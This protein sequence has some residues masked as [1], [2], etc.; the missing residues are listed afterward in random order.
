MKG[1]ERVGE[2][3][4]GFPGGPEVKALPFHCRGLGFDPWLGNLNPTYLTAQPREK[5]NTR[6]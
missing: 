4:R 2:R 5:R 3:T 1:A 6:G